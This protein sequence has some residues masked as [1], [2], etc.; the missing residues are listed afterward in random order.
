M[1]T[2][3]AEPV[4]GPSHD[5]SHF[6][7]TSQ[8]HSSQQLT[9][10]CLPVVVE[11]LTYEDDEFYDVREYDDDDGGDEGGGGTGDDGSA[12]ADDRGHQLASSN[13]R[14][15]D[16]MSTVVSSQCHSTVPHHSAS[17]SVII[18]DSTDFNYYIASVCVFLFSMLIKLQLDT[19][20][21]PTFKACYCD[22]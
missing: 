9:S 1:T 17:T 20:A 6:R 12:T 5:N 8:V 13:S 18:S 4:A 19:H 22:L 15:S 16:A 14:A 11:N 21:Y 10:V 3:V 7:M 2:D